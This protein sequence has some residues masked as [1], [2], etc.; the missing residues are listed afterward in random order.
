MNEAVSGRD[1]LVDVGRDEVGVLLGPAEEEVEL[2]V[3][4]GGISRGK[5]TKSGKGLYEKP[6]NNIYGAR[7]HIVRASYPHTAI[8]HHATKFI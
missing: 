6:R 2:V 8:V 7:K 3:L 4:E 5:V 1:E